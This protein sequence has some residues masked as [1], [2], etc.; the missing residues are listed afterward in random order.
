MFTFAR[1]QDLAIGG[2]HLRRCEVVQRQ[3]AA[4]GQIA[5]PASERQPRN[6]G[7][8]DDPACGRQSERVGRIVEISPRGPALGASRLRACI[9]VDAAHPRQIRDDPIVDGAE[10]RD[11]VPPAADREGQIVVTREVDRRHDVVRVDA[12]NDGARPA[13]DHRV[14]HRS[15]LVVALV[16]R[17]H[18]LTVCLLSELFDR[19][20]HRS[21]SLV[22]AQPVTC[23]R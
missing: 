4:P 7:R 6:T 3:A 8:R 17:S 9:D 19:S 22:G 18:D 21:P 5:D 13:V 16:G 2:D 10:A 23:F 1:G 20:G 12:A 11:A 14:V 15:G